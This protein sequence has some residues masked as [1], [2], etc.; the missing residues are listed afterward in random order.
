MNK[1]LVTCDLW[2]EAGRGL[3]FSLCAETSYSITFT[4]SK[5]SSTLDL[6]G[7]CATAAVYCCFAINLLI[8]YFHISRKKIYCNCIC[9]NYLIFNHLSPKQT[10]NSHSRWLFVPQNK[11]RSTLGGRV[12]RAYVWS[13]DADL[14]NVPS[15]ICEWASIVVITCSPMI[16]L[17]LHKSD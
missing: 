5:L 12:W 8:H 11:S 6:K 10:C 9:N 2:R 1:H 7:F 14:E 13:A 4:L 16:V 17:C 15:Q 3:V